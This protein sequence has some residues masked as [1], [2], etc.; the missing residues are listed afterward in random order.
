TDNID[1]SLFQPVPVFVDGLGNFI[2]LKPELVYS[3]SI[4]D[5]FPPKSVQ[6]D[7][8]VYIESLEN[9]GQERINEMINEVGKKIMPHQ[10]SKFFDF[11]FIAMHGPACEDGSLQG[12]FEWYGVPYSGPSLLGSAI[13]IDKVAQNDLIKLSVG[14]NKKTYLLSRTAF[15]QNDKVLLFDEIKQSLGLPFVVKAPHQGSSIGVAFVKIDE[16]GVFEKAVKQCLFVF[17]IER[18]IWLNFT[19]EERHAFLQSCANMDEGVGFPLLFE[20]EKILLPLE[21]GQ[22]LDLFFKENQSV[23]TATW[24][25]IHTEN[26]VLLE[27]FVSGQEFSCGVIQTPNGQAVALPPTEIK[28]AVEVFD[29]KAKYQSNTT[30]KN[31]PIQTSLSNNQAVQSEVRKVFEDLK[32]GVCTRIDGFLSPTDEVI[33]HDPNTIPGM[34]PSSLIF[35]QMAEIGLNVTDAIT[36]FIRQSLFERMKTAKNT[37]H[38]KQLLQSLD[39]AIENRINDFAERKTVA[40]FWGG[41]TAEEKESSYAL[42]KIAYAKIAASDK[43]LAKIFYVTDITEK[44]VGQ[45]VDL[46]LNMLFKESAEAVDTLLSN[47]LHPLIAQT[48][49]NAK[50]ITLHFTGKMLESPQQINF[51]DT[52]KGHSY[53]QSFVTNIVPPLFE[54]SQSAF[55]EKYR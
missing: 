12:I 39:V 9:L 16:Q 31:I 50:A 10:F 6:G 34:S 54:L 20:G 19:P 43:F 52:L 22:K 49:E 13:G 18:N 7:F 53:Y 55:D 2:L 40:L 17:E 28:P 46:P 47:E 29:F 38:F 3:S 15:E 37:F 45:I 4:R 14:L 11:A 24:E 48:R 36:Y 51:E 32:F 30:R 8:N 26:S 27:A 41:N 35:K 21:F 44:N 33:L 23:N 25:A 1:Q 5:F 42:V